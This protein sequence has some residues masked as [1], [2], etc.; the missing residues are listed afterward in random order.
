MGGSGIC[1]AVG[2][3]DGL[4]CRLEA[5]NLIQRACGAMGLE[6]CTMGSCAFYK[7]PVSPATLFDFLR[8]NLVDYGHTS[9]HERK[10]ARLFLSACK[11]A[12]KS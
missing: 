7:D 9:A 5:G 4:C 12:L 11:H 8:S 3:V 10:F 1:S 2:A 6:D